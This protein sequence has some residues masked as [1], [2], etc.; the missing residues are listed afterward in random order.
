MDNEVKTFN[1]ILC[2]KIRNHKQLSTVFKD[3]SMACKK[4]VDEIRQSFSY[5]IGSEQVSKAEY[6]KRTKGEE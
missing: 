3:G 2:K 6:D 4:C 1:C 5:Y